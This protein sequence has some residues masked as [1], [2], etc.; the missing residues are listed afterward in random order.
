MSEAGIGVSGRPQQS[1][2]PK[3]RNPTAAFWIGFGLSVLAATFAVAS[4][5]LSVAESTRYAWGRGQP[6]DISEG[7]SI[8]L[9]GTRGFTQ[10]VLSAHRAEKLVVR[11][12]CSISSDFDETIEIFATTADANPAPGF[13]VTATDTGTFRLTIGSTLLAD[14]PRHLEADPHC[15][16]EATIDRGGHWV[17]RSN[18]DVV[19]EGETAAPV[20][21]GIGSGYEVPVGSGEFIAAEIETVPHGP[22]S[23]PARSLFRIGAAVL[24]AA[25]IALLFSLQRGLDGQGSP[26]ASP[27]RPPLP[28]TPPRSRNVDIGVIVTLLAWWLVGP[29]GFDDGWVMAT[30]NNFPADGIFGVYYD[31]YNAALPFGYAHDTLIRAFATISPALLWLRIPA[32]I[33]AVVTWFLTRSTVD[34]GARVLG[35]VPPVRIYTASVFLLSWTSWN[36]SVRPEPFIA[37]LVAVTLWAAVC[38]QATSKPRFMLITLFAI[39]LAISIHPTGV[40]TLAAP[41]LL[42][43]AL[44]AWLRIHTVRGWLWL[45]SITIL[46]AAGL[47]LLLGSVGDWDFWT[48]S[49]SQLTAAHYSLGP[50]GEPERYRTLFNDGWSNSMRQLAVLLPLT[51]PAM[52]FFRSRRQRHSPLDTPVLALLVGLFALAFTPSKWIWHFGVLTPLAAAAVGL[53]LHRWRVERSLSPKLLGRLVLI[54][55]TVAIL[56]ATWSGGFGWNHLALT[57]VDRLL[58]E[59]PATLRINYVAVVSVVTLVM[60]TVLVFGNR[61]KPTPPA[62]HASLS[63]IPA[64]A[65]T[66]TLVSLAAFVADTVAA[67]GWAAGRQNLDEVTSGTC[68][69]ADQIMVETSEGIWY[70]AGEGPG[71]G[72]SLQALSIQRGGSVLVAPQIRPYFPCFRQ[73]LIQDGV[74]ES[75][76]MIVGVGGWPYRLEQ[77]PFAYLGNLFDLRLLTN[78]SSNSLWRQNIEVILVDQYLQVADVP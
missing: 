62:S 25:T 6:P 37:M 1:E 27:L 53:E 57:G 28:A 4:G 66:A 20:I 77:S 32:L 60:I 40:V 74:A 64:V 70:L 61:R 55:T 30:V 78:R 38:F 13:R 72:V 18:D 75:P 45:T 49:S 35:L 12:S 2:P 36:N 54:L 50:V 24:I 7:D 17:L 21:T 44:S 59:I 8:V 5:F 43:P 73:P 56:A 23:S 31:I 19:G 65:L 67:Q 22:S 29:V 69:L 48:R 63:L 46:S 16:Y 14:P 52:F 71:E 15:A 68:G 11:W 51:A 3:P 10:L 76:S 39:S 41:L 47:V 42:L 58:A 26:G 9:D 34:L 33:A